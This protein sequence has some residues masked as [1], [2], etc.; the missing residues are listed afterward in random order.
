MFTY[1]VINTANTHLFRQGAAH[2]PCGRKAANCVEVNVR[3]GHAAICSHCAVNYRAQGQG[4]DV[5]S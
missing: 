1:I 2:A 4:F 3:L 5:L